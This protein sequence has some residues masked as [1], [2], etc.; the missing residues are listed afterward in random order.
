MKYRFKNMYFSRA[1]NTIF[2]LNQHSKLSSRQCAS[3]QLVF[4]STASLY[5][6]GPEYAVV[7]TKPS[8][9]KRGGGSEAAGGWAVVGKWAR[10]GRSKSQDEA[11]GRNRRSSQTSD[12]YE[13][14]AV[15]SAQT[16]KGTYMLSR[17]GT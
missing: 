12:F 15:S 9:S 2:T 16:S 3:L 5:D 1:E 17:K 13:I 11:G 10:R 4:S 8:S 14:L 6:A 7:A